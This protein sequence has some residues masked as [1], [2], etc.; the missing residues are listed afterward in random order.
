MRMVDH[1]GGC[2]GIKHVFNMDNTTAEELD[3]YLA[4]I[5][6]PANPNR[7]T[8]VVLSARQVGIGNSMLHRNPQTE[9]GWPAI[10]NA[11]GFRLVSRFKNS[12]SDN[13]VFV[14]HH[15]P[16][17][18][19]LDPNDMG[20]QMRNW[21]HDYVIPAEAVATMTTPRVAVPRNVADNAWVAS[22]RDN[23]QV[24]TRVRL[25]ERVGERPQGLTGVAT[26]P[27]SD[28][29][30]NPGWYIHWDGRDVDPHDGYFPFYSFEVAVEAP[31]N[32][33]VVGSRVRRIDAN[34][35][36][37]HIAVG[38]VGTV[39]RI[40]REAGGRFLSVRTDSGA[41]CHLFERRF[42][43]VVED[44]AV[45]AP[46]GWAVGDRFRYELRNSRRNGWIGTITGQTGTRWTGVFDN[47]EDFNLSSTYFR[48]IEEPVTQQ[49]LREAVLDVP[50]VEPTPEPVIVFSTYHNFFRGLER[51]SPAGFDTLEEAQRAAPR[52]RRRDRRD[53]FSDGSIVWSENV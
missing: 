52:C 10:L 5:C 28:T 11:R 13:E 19:S 47:G 17:F 3:R 30:R 45:E 22:S 39:T 38:S 33:I 15:V 8:E 46:R 18:L 48:R 4:E 6:T 37:N 41:V 40:E 14:F 35:G 43:L 32:Q 42:E 16:N 50:A 1:G 2:C 12:N 34:G 20:G 31:Q 44:V 26:R 9:G 24:G 49:E 25:N 23:V 53:I 27:Y 29:D 7:L 21:R 36:A 51:R